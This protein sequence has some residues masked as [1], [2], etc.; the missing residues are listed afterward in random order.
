M[1]LIECPTC[2]NEISTLVP[3]CPRCGRPIAVFEDVA[4]RTRRKV[5]PLFTVGV[6]LI[7]AG[8]MIAFFSPLWG[9]VLIAV[10]A[11]AIG[12]GR[13]RDRGIRGS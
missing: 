4:S 11:I 9:G 8:F 12:F 2:G 10:G 3:A 1:N 6:L 7:S 5:G 13:S